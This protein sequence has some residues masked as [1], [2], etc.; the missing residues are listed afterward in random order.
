MRAQIKDSRL[1]NGE[2]ILKA[3]AG[4]AGPHVR[5]INLHGFFQQ[6]GLGLSKVMLLGTI[7]RPHILLGLQPVCNASAGTDLAIDILSSSDT[8][9][10]DN[11]NL[12]DDHLSGGTLAGNGWSAYNGATIW[13][14]NKLV[15][16]RFTVYKLAM[17]NNSAAT[18]TFDV[19]LTLKL[20]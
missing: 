1:D 2:R 19:N 7:T 17:R 6:A 5:F 4:D 3:M 18:I 11:A 8:L 14:I 16:A 13:T 9:V 12:R 10:D 15:L 20:I